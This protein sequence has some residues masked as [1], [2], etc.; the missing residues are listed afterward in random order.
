MSKL[1]W[2]FAAYTLT[3]L[4]T[5]CLDCGHAK[6]ESPASFKIR[7]LAVDANEGIA[8]ADVNGDGKPD[9]VAGRFWYQNPEWIPRPLRSIEDWNGYV[10]SNGDYIFDVN[11]DGKPDVVAGSF[12]PSEVYWYEN[13]GERGL[14]LGQEWQ[15]FLLVDTGQQ[16]NE[17]ILFEDVDGDGQVEWVANS[18]AK[19]VP[20]YV[21]RLIPKEPAKAKPKGKGKNQVPT[22][23]AAYK[24]VP[25]MI[26]DA[27]NGHGLGIGDINGDGRKDILVGQGWYEQPESNP[28]EQKWKF[29]KVWELHASLPMLIVD[30]NGDGRNDLIHGKGHDFGLMW[31]ENQGAGDDGELQF[32]EHLIDR[33][34]SQPHSL[35][36]GDLTGD[37]NPE[38]ITG[39]RYYAHNGKDAGGEEP[40]CMYYYTLDTKQAK[41]TRHTIEEGSVGTGLQIVVED[42]NGD[43]RNDLAVAGKSGTHLLL[44]HK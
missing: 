5:L 36:W 43:G 15:K 1:P 17:G 11:K 31:W 7:K 13:P 39:K 35:A 23:T 16:R 30:V 6:A 4:V 24:M 29:H 25:T 12:V 19:D 22:D 20:M 26:G 44:N 10:Q 42:F 14:R 41:F 3:G 28:W 27:G 37:G 34:Y 40:P 2:L 18:W 9:I 38:L 33:E 21:C 32:K 8:A